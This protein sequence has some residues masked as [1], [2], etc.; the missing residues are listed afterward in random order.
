MFGEFTNAFHPSRPLI[1]SAI[2]VS[3][4]AFF[5]TTSKIPKTKGMSDD[6]LNFR[7]K[8]KG[9]TTLLIIIL[10]ERNKN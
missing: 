2:F 5:V 9:S 10:P 8:R 6:K 7:P 4:K 1:I 3:N